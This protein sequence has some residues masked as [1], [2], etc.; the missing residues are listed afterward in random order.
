MVVIA[1]QLWAKLFPKQAIPPDDAAGRQALVRLVLAELSKDHGK[2][3]NLVAD[4]QAT[5]DRIKAFIRGRDILRLPDPDRCRVIEMPEF[6]R[7]YSTAYLNPAPPL[8]AA[9]E[10]VYAVSPPPKDWDART[11]ESYLR[12]YD[13]AMLQFSPSTRRTPATTSSWRTR[14]GTRRWSGR[15]STTA[16]SPRAGRCTPSR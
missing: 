10:S 13:S 6:Q 2:V 7:G 4:A 1:R 3:E 5:V 8:D 11:V 14:A 15:C 9:A 16:R 12:E